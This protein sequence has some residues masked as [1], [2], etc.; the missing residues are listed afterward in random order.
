[1][2]ESM[3][4]EVDQLPD[5]MDRG[6]Q[7]QLKARAVG[8]AYDHAR[9]AYRTKLQKRAIAV[10]FLDIKLFLNPIPKRKEFDLMSLSECFLRLPTLLPFFNQTH[11]LLAM[12]FNFV[13]I[14]H[15]LS[16]KLNGSIK[17]HKML[18][19]EGLLRICIPV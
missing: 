18:L 5:H 14:L 1:M 19:A 8:I 16:A 7:R 13:H 6:A 2:T 9:N 15:F 17:A 11:H 10:L 12:C 3:A 4:S